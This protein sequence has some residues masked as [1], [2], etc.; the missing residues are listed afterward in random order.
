[1]MLFELLPLF[2]Q[3]NALWIVLILVS[4]L[5]IS[6]IFNFILFKWRSSV[7][8]I[9]SG[10]KRR[11]DR[12]LTY[13]RQYP[14]SWY[15]ICDSDEVNKGQVKHICALGQEMVA[16]RGED[17]VA[18][19]LDAFCIHMGANLGYGGT[20]VG[21]C[22]QCPFHLWEF[23]TNG[24]CTKIPYSDKIPPNANIF[25]YPCVEKYGMIMIWY[26]PNREP[27]HY[28]AISVNDIDDN[29]NTFVARGKYKYPNIKMH[30]QEFAE[31]SAD[32]QHFGPLHGTM[33]IPWT[34]ILIPFIK[35]DHTASFALG[36]EKHIAYFY[37][38]AMLKIFGEKYP[39]TKV[40]ASIKFYGPGGI[41]LF[42]FDGEFGRLYLFHC[43]TPTDYTCLDVEFLAFIEKKIPRL[44]S[45]YIIGNWIAQWKRDI[46]VWENK[47]Y[48][49]APFLV[50]TDGPIMKM[51]RWYK[52]FYVQK[53]EA[54]DW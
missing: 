54:F 1:M 39:K 6:L 13:P 53:E 3:I 29:T 2:L 31:N 50:K 30:L 49:R 47:V 24:V 36:Y 40:D 27:P 19:V 20:V 9:Y 21:N 52:E 12:H 7:L 37:D 15:R 32:S 16:F 4:I 44:L 18:C 5:V 38:T 17:G 33:I 48:K 26:H 22:I 42:Q 14:C 11:V 41:T 45:W 25:A 8:R 43:H 28:D 51:R 35:I 46:V 23:G 10:K 34:E